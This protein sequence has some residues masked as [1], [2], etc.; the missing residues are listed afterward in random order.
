MYY[1]NC[2]CTRRAHTHI[3]VFR[4]DVYIHIVYM[5]IYVRHHHIH[6]SFAVLQ[7]SFLRTPPIRSLSPIQF[8][9]STGMV[10]C[11]HYN[12]RRI[13]CA[14]CISLSRNIYTNASNWQIILWLWARHSWRFFTLV[15]SSLNKSRISCIVA[16]ILFG[17]THINFK[18]I[19]Y[20]PFSTVFLFKNKKSSKSLPT[21]ARTSFRL[22]KN[23]IS[24]PTNFQRN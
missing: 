22:L 12:S 15:V 14:L 8:N 13:V 10:D 21:Y 23:R 16:V 2:T 1:T 24:K 20:G 19:N 7:V 11:T 3:S 6:H 18:K 9:D 4:T 17:R 5:F